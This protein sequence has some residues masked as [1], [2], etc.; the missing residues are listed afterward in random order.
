MRKPRQYQLVYQYTEK[1]KPPFVKYYSVVTARSKKEAVN[2]F[3]LKHCSGDDKET[4]A[5]R[6]MLREGLRAHEIK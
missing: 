6:A 3:I 1:G 4:V 5:L 2:G